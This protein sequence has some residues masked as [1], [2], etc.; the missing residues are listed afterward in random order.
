MLAN[1]P[2]TGYAGRGSWWSSSMS[3]SDLERELCLAEIPVLC[4][5]G[6]PPALIRRMPEGELN[7]LHEGRDVAGYRRLQ[8]GSVAI[9]GRVPLQI[10]DP[11]TAL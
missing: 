11:R 4:M 7:E 2:N 9:L 5:V 3:G 1:I 8:G 10:I 6:H